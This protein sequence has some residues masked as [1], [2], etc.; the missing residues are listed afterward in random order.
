MPDLSLEQRR[1]LLESL[2]NGTFTKSKVNLYYFLRFVHLTHGAWVPKSGTAEDTEK[3]RFVNLL[4]GKTYKWSTVRE[5]LLFSCNQCEELDLVQRMRFQRSDY[6]RVVLLT[7]G[8]RV[9]GYLEL[10]LHLRRERIQIPLQ[11]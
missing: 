8:S 5:L 10:F 6:D 2:T 7:L 9:L 3:L 1:V 4:F 11:L